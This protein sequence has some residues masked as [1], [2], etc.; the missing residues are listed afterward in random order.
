MGR[1]N[2][3]GEGRKK[4][5]ERGKKEGKRR[6]KRGKEQKKGGKGR[7]KEGKAPPRERGASG[8]RAGAGGCP[9]PRSGDTP[10]PVPA[11]RGSLL[12]AN[13]SPCTP[14]SPSCVSLERSR[15]VSAPFCFWGRFFFFFFSPLLLSIPPPGSRLPAPRSFPFSPFL[16]PRT[17]RN[18]KKDLDV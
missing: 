10:A 7:K 14:R 12:C 3:G 11:G 18:F 15:H 16:S 4:G 17:M 1:R 2:K 13:G 5:A 8:T 9:C 6:E